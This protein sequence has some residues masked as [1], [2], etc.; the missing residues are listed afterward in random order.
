MKTPTPPW[1]LTALLCVVV[2][3]AVE[4]T[5][6]VACLALPRYFD[7]RAEVLDKLTEASLAAYRDGVASPVLGWVP[8]PGTETERNCAGRD[9]SATVTGDLRRAN[10]PAAAAAGSIAILTAGDSYTFGA[11]VDDGETFPARLEQLLGV[12]VANLGVSA[13]D[14]LQAVLRLEQELPHY[15]N[16]R[17]LVLG[18]MY[19]NLLRLENSFRSVYVLASPTAYTFKPYAR[20]GSIRGV[21]R[22]DPWRDVATA[23]AAIN[24]AFDT[25][26]WAKPGRAFP[27]TRALA[28]VFASNEFLFRLH[29]AIDPLRGVPRRDYAVRHPEIRRNLAAVLQRFAGVGQAAMKRVVLLI[30]QNGA[31]FPSRG[32]VEAMV[33]AASPP[34]MALASAGEGLDPAQYN[35][36]R[37]GR[38]HPSPYGYAA[39]ADA[40]AAAL[41]E[42]D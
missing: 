9:W 12:P 3:A 20:D 7:R 19:E 6:F 36:G 4:L 15:P 32:L 38:C 1:V 29:D 2:A 8:R 33:R 30:P 18:I 27:Y 17:A 11:E 25:D 23:T 5:A 37:T 41:R 21:P 35:I 14:P 10:G 34:G 40:A 16:A 26:F 39:I 22:G 42:R 31:D 24:E 28:R 13:Y